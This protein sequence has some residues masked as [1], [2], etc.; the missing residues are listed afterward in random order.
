MSTQQATRMK[1]TLQQALLTLLTKQPFTKITMTQIAK[2]ALVNRT[3]VY[4]HYED[5]FALLAATLQNQLAVNTITPEMFTTQPFASIAL[6]CQGMPAHAFERQRDD[7]A[8][9]SVFLRLLFHALK[10]T[11]LAP[12]GL[13]AYLLIWQ[14]RA[15]VSWVRETNQP[16]NLYTAGAS[17]DAKLVQAKAQLQTTQKTGHCT[18]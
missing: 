12:T 11:D 16:D 8:F 9:R 2:Q 7:L 13:S 10:Q 15:V 17:L 1:K 14:I 3:T 18:D 5:K 4:A 6:L